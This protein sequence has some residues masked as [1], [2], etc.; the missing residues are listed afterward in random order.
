MKALRRQSLT[1]AI[2]LSLL[3]SLP[4][5]AAAQDAPAPAQPGSATTLD[6]V[7]VT[8][9]RIKQTNVVTAQPVYVLDRSK[10]EA[11]GLQSVGDLLQ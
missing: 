10:I 11:T 2:Q 4:G 7:T 5:I 8:G 9:S 6:T 1:R 3:L